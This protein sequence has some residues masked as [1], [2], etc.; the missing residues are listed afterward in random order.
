MALVRAHW[1]RLAH[2]VSPKWVSFVR[3]VFL[4]AEL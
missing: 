2:R 1:V 4:Q 3:S